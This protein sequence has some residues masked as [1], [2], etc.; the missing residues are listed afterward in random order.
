MVFCH[1]RGQIVDGTI[2]RMPLTR[3][4]KAPAGPP[5][6][7][8]HASQAPWCVEYNSEGFIGYV[9]DGPFLFHD[10]KN[11]LTLLWSSFSKDGYSMGLAHSSD[12]T[13]TGNWTHEAQ[14][15]IS[16]RG[17]H[18]MV[19]DSLDGKRLLA[20]HGPNENHKERAVFEPFSL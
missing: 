3:D 9:T 20:Y 17:G 2:E 4:L 15:L 18:G 10:R 1:E 16:G 11:R 12:G 6:T 19:F 7:L 13:L 5:V 14:P 8:F